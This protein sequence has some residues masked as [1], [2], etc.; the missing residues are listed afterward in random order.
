[1]TKVEDVAAAFGDVAESR[2]SASESRP[3]RLAEVIEEPG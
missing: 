2:P 3:D 1:M